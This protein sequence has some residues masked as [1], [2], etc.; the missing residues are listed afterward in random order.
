MPDSNTYNDNVQSWAAHMDT[1]TE[2]P[3]IKKEPGGFEP[4]IQEHRECR[5]GSR[6]TTS[7]K[8]EREQD[9][10]DQVQS[11]N[12]AQ[13]LDC[14]VKG[15]DVGELCVKGEPVTMKQLDV[16]VQQSPTIQG[17][18]QLGEPFE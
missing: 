9:D 1:D 10:M 4:W 2:E 8:R 6:D 17:R 7:L 16:I 11:D 18:V 12:D 14:Q 5:F 3:T 13:Y 15:G